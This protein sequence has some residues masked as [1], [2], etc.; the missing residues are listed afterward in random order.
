[1]AQE[2]EHLEQIQE[3]VHDAD[4][5]LFA[6]KITKETVVREGKRLY[7]S[8]SAE[9]TEEEA[10]FGEWY[11]YVGNLIYSNNPDEIEFCNKIVSRLEKKYTAL[12]NSGYDANKIGKILEE[13]KYEQAK[14][15][16]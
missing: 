8:L 16:I 4:I 9:Y 12:I 3:Q 6:S 14:R 1:M 13:I 5:N 2:T 15:N 10:D 11:F 7:L